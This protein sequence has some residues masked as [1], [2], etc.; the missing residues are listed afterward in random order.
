MDRFPDAKG[1]TEAAT[2]TRDLQVTEDRFTKGWAKS[3][4]AAHHLVLQEV[5]SRFAR[6]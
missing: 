4:A 1:N 6:A 5:A 3:A 2:S